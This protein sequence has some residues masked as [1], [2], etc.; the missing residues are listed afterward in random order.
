[1]SGPV[2]LRPIRSG[3][4]VRCEE[5]LRALPDW[6]GIESALLEYVEATRTEP[7]VMAETDSGVL[8]FLTLHRHN[9]HSAEIQCMAVHP[10]HHARGVGRALVREAEAMAAAGGAEFLEVKT[11]GPSRPDPNYERTREF[12]RRMGFRPLEENALW[13]KV[14]PCLILVKH[15]PCRPPEA[16]ARM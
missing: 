10:D 3:E 11:L 9:P 15:L 2:R 6:F 16:P 12:Y 14:N 13:G 5:I 8:G 1:M 7:T 4:S